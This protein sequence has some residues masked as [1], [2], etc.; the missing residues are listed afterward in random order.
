MILMV[1]KKSLIFYLL[2]VLAQICYSQEY[3]TLSGIVKNQSNQPVEDV[4]VSV[5]GQDDLIFTDDK[6]EFSIKLEK[7]KSY[8]LDIRSIEIQTIKKT[9]ILQKDST[10]YFEVTESIISL[11]ETLKTLKEQQFTLVKRPK[12]F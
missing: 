12:L 6:G 5:E 8:L 10:I 9:I 11:K 1:Q 2:V 3:A 4:W 7:N